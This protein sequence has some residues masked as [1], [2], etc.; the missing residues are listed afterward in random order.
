MCW[1]SLKSRLEACQKSLSSSEERCSQLR[2]SIERLQQQLGTADSAQS[3][4]K[5]QAAQL[6]RQ[7]S[8][9]NGQLTQV[10]DKLQQVRRLAM[11]LLVLT[12]CVDPESARITLYL[13]IS[14][15]LKI[16]SAPPTCS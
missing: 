4:L 5:D 15:R 8:E 14:R 3:E 9:A 1:Q 7:L 16:G 10:Q 12:K 13:V 11:G 2:V 6:S